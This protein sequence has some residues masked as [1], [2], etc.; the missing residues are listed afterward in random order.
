MENRPRITDEVKGQQLDTTVLKEAGKQ[1]KELE[2]R[3]KWEAMAAAEKKQK[4]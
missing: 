3:S 1:W 2:D 4:A